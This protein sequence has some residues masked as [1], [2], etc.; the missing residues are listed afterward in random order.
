MWSASKRLRSKTSAVTG[1]R[2]QKPRAKRPDLLSDDVE[3]LALRLQ[4]DFY[5]GAQGTGALPARRGSK[6][7]VGA[8]IRGVTSNIGE[9]TNFKIARGR[10]ISNVDTQLRR[11]VCVIGQD[12]V[13][14]LFPNDFPVGKKIR[15]GQ[16][17]YTVIGVAAEQ[18]STFGNSQ[19]GFVQI[20]LGTFEKVFG[21]RSRSLSIY[22]KARED[23]GISVA[24]TE[25][26]VIVAMRIRRGLVSTGKPNNF[27]ILTADSIQAFAG[28][29]TGLVGTIFYPLTVIALFVGGVVVMNMMLSSVTERTKE[30]GIRKAVGASRGDI[31]MQF[32]VETVVL[33]LVGG[34]LGLGV[35]LLITTTIGFGFGLPITV[36]LWSVFLAIFVSSTVGIVFGLIPARKAAGLDPIESLRYE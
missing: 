13:D 23:S 30:I 4:K 3:Y 24:E 16:I 11:N 36:P 15:L 2:L 6:T 22:V 31:L 20:P 32:L 18:G 10:P 28:N 34:I 12:I 35:A 26:Q 25:E 27:S 21:K 7:V 5:V 19:D 17:E 29:L 8:S 9:L 33:T 1:K 14:E